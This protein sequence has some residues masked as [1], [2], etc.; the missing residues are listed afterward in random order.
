MSR[1]SDEF[2]VGYLPKAPQSLARFVRWVV[3]AMLA[4][5]ATIA[6]LLMLA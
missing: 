4:A 2:Y 5:G 6:L 1:F 3:F